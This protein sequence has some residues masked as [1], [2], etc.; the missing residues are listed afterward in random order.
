MN[1]VQGEFSLYARL[2]LDYRLTGS[3]FVGTRPKAVVRPEGKYLSFN[4][5]KKDFVDFRVGYLF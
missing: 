1:N 2:G 5:I 3:L 4:F